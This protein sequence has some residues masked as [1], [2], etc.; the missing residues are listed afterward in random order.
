M[1]PSF[2]ALRI[3]R[4][5]GSLLDYWIN[6]Q[7]RVALMNCR[8][9]EQ[10][11]RTFLCMNSISM[12]SYSYARTYLRTF[13]D[14]T[15]ELLPKV[16][17]ARKFLI[18]FRTQWHIGTIYAKF[19]F[20]FLLINKKKHE[21]RSGGSRMFN[22]NLREISWIT[23]RAMCCVFPWDLRTSR[24]SYPSLGVIDKIPFRRVRF[25][26]GKCG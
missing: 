16:N 10:D 15:P 13:F 7:S 18:N 12:H 24:V 5:Q 14:F 23:A 22:E 26:N 11:F 9:I 17:L 2:I 19:R 20:F 25:H 4:D 6:K 8:I 1:F 3:L 21:K